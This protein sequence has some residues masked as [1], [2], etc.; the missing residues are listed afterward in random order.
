MDSLDQLSE[1]LAEYGVWHAVVRTPHD[2]R[3]L[4]AER[5][6]EGQEREVWLLSEEPG[7]PDLLHLQF[8]QSVVGGGSRITADRAASAL[9]PA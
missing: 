8:G 5:L 1:T 9:V 3:V 2:T 4:V 7:E 6:R